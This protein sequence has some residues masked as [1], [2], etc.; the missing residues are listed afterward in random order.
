MRRGTGSA[1]AASTHRN[2]NAGQTTLS[3]PARSSSACSPDVG[4]SGSPSRLLERSG[5]P[6]RPRRP[7]V[8]RLPEPARPAA[9]PS[10]LCPTALSPPPPSV[11][12]LPPSPSV[13]PRP[14]PPRP[15]PGPEAMLDE[16]EDLL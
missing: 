6:I 14:D 15:A 7:R 10:P 13:L 1:S 16:H 9:S 3:R 4:L 11:L 8:S 12:P 2:D 5:P